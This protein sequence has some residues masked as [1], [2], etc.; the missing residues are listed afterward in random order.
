MGRKNRL[1]RYQPV[2]IIL[3]PQEEMRKRKRG[4][5][6]RRYGPQASESITLLFAGVIDCRRRHIGGRRNADSLEACQFACI[7]LKQEREISPPSLVCGWKA[8]NF[9]R[10]CGARCW[11]LR[12]SEA[13]AGMRRRRRSSSSGATCRR[14]FTA[15]DGHAS[16]TTTRRRLAARPSGRQTCL[17]TA[18]HHVCQPGNVVDEREPA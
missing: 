7:I 8:R 16:T 2:E 13:H 4:G 15:L 1:R 5:G 12:E 11:M 14:T 9:R 3:Y 10:I 18:G 6:D 17:I